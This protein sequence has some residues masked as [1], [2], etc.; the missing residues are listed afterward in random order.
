M[1]IQQPDAEQFAIKPLSVVVGK[2]Q[3]EIKWCDPVSCNPSRSTQCVLAV[4][5]TPNAQMGHAIGPPT[6]EKRRWIMREALSN[7]PFENLFDLLLRRRDTISVISTK[8]R[9]PCAEGLNKETF[10]LG[11]LR[12]NV[13]VAAG[14]R[15]QVTELL[16]SLSR[17]SDRWFKTRAVGGFACIGMLSRVFCVGNFV[18]FR[19][20]FHQQ[21]SQRTFMQNNQYPRPNKSPK[22]NVAPSEVYILVNC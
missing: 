19:D 16:R 11:P 9:V 17:R 18:N 22:G 13:R 10:G 6:T 3:V 1:Y 5:L 14:R 7:E 8:V 12:F 4:V 2:C 15:L 20:C 21:L